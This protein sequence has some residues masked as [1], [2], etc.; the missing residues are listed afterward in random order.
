MK[1]HQQH[2]LLSIVCATLLLQGCAAV[3]VGTA[4]VAS[5]ALVMHDRR[6]TGT[7]IDDN[8]IEFKAKRR[9]NEKGEPTANGNITAISYN[10][11]VLLVGQAPDESTRQRATDIVKGVPKVRKV[12]N[13]IRISGF[14]TYLSRTNDAYITSK[15][16][17][18]FLV[19]KGIDPTRIKVV[20]E[21]GVVYLLGLVTA[22]EGEIATEIARNTGGVQQVVQIFE[23]YQAK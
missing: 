7:F 1:L 16:K 20:T 22:E 23:R 8:S 3:V 12:H 13:Q 2:F 10:H 11:V 5:G 21:T 9:L 6:T 15:I 18:Q 17:S 4:A 14:T 19:A